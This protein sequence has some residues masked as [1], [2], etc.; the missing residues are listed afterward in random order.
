LPAE[1]LLPVLGKKFKNVEQHWPNVSV[2]FGPFTLMQGWV[3]INAENHSD[4]ILRLLNLFLEIDYLIDET[5]QHYKLSGAK[6]K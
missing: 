1:I 4:E 6:K 3:K 5:L 2:R